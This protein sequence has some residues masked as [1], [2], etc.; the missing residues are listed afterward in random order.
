MLNNAREKLLTLEK[1]GRYTGGEVNAV[2]KKISPDIT[3]FA[4]C[5]PD[6]YE[7]GMSHLGLQI[8]YFFL[9]RREDV[10]CER[11]FMP[12][13]DMAE[14]LRTENAPLFALESGDA[15]GEFDFLGF[16]L[17]YEMSYTNVLAMLDLA[18][19]PLKSAERGDNF[20]II[21]AGGPCAVNP[22]PM[23]EFIDFF[24]IGDGEAGLDKI[25]DVRQAHN[26]HREHVSAAARTLEAGKS[27]GSRKHISAAAHSLEAGKSFE[28]REHVS[29][30]AHSLEAGKSFGS[31]GGKLAF[32]REISTIPGVYVPALYDVAYNNDG[33]IAKF[34]PK[35][36]TVRS[37]VSDEGV[38]GTLSPCGGAGAESPQASSSVET[39]LPQTF[40]TRAH[41][42]KLEFFPDKLI[43]PLVEATHARAVVEIARGCGRGCRFCQAGFICRP[44]RERGVDELLAQAEKILNATGY[45]EISLLSLSA[46]DYRNFEEL[47][48]GLL[49]ICAR[50][51]V[52]ISLPSTR[53]DALHVISKIKTLRT[54]SLT[55]APEAGSQRLRD[56]IKKGLTEDE[57][58]DGCFRAYK[59]GFDKI[60][61]Y[62]MGGLPGESDAD[63]FAAVELCEK[64]VEKYY[65]LP[66]EER[67]RPVSVSVS[68]SCFV[69]KP[70]TP[71]QWAAQESPEEFSRRQREAKA[72]VRKRQ[73]S[74]RYHDAKT[75]HI[76]GIL[77][78]GDRRLA[79]AIE[80][81]YRAGAMF[82][83]WTEHFRYETWL[84]AFEQTGI[85]P[86]F[87]TR[88]RGADEI[89]PWS[90][91]DMGLKNDFL[92]RE[93]E[94]AKD[95]L[96]TA[97]F[98]ANSPEK[99]AQASSEGVPNT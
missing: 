24:Y 26:E 83:G 23:A 54:N 45:E 15:L 31:S 94:R 34:A 90:F 19:I 28:S 60:K 12:W 36:E 7:I 40:I 69:P 56:A 3:R 6:V 35:P 67:K 85:D 14:L 73:I 39:K 58:L 76:E 88:E 99:S 75:A 18:G 13:P 10:F 91:I 86:A 30:A 55:V 98:P 84:A 97:E 42:P 21:C 46:C 57:I 62:F 61:L 82:D 70:F 22:E 51:R 29:A 77:A 32:L 52:N 47:V 8:L 72:A 37:T 68:T 44:V 53:L 16:T 95:V 11:A 41:I 33:T 89:L 59:A 48:D 17:Q 64:I 87:Y 1:P 50:K 93:W 63:A 9:N 65:E 79:S 4:F 96:A 66:Y 49:E 74:Y 5:F 81:A 71:F 38:K 20:P 25:M 80:A 92:R 43:V 78:R 27:F 2:T